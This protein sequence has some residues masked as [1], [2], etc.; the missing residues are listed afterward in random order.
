VTSPDAESALLQWRSEFP[1]LGRSVYLISNSLG[2]MPRAAERGLAE[3][4]A[5]WSERGVRAWAEGW[6]DMPVR[7]GDLAAP[8]LGVG[9]G[10]VSFQPNV[11]LATAAIL[12]CFD[13][14]GPRRAIVTTSMEFPSL[15]YL[16]EGQRGRGAR[17]TIVESD[18][19]VGIDLE[20]LLRAIDEETQIVVVS[21]VLFRSAF[22]QDADA[23]V[24]RAH[25][26]GAH[27]LLDVY[28]SAGTV[29]IDAARLDV[30]C[31]VGGCLKWLCGG[32]GAAFLY[33][34]PDLRARLRPALTGWMAH[35]N[36]FGF[37]T[38]PIRLREDA[39]RFLAGTP[40]IPAL[41][42][43]RAGL[44]IIASVGIEAIRRK[45]VRQVARLVD[46]A[47]AAGLAVTVP[48]RPEQRGGTVAIAAPHAYEVSRELLRRE[49]LVDY[50]PGAGIRVSPHFYT[51]DGEL[52]DV[53]REIERIL[54]TRAYEAHVGA[55]A[56]VT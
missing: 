35:E 12:S 4:A 21:H 55:R 14:T 42:G 34:R 16:C 44:E 45:S 19:G 33:V 29:P 32:P 26:V 6:W 11:T 7:L 37:E 1:I 52:E 49:F 23:I 43:A 9:G 30:D 27:V 40:A 2:A 56:Y 48:E 15:L 13:F 50:R 17:L 24:R 47:R 5:A 25:E 36:A 28:Q 22:I 10:A 20:R 46:L 38:G 53:V 8:I 31:V 39:F 51:A 54:E 3:Y 41:Y 18:D